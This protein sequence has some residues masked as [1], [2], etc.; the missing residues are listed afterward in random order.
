MRKSILSRKVILEWCCRC[1]VGQKSVNSTVWRNLMRQRSEPLQVTSQCCRLIGCTASVLQSG[2]LHTILN[3]CR[4]ID[5][6]IVISEVTNRE[7]AI[8]CSTGVHF[9]VSPSTGSLLNRKPVS[10]GTWEK[11][12]IVWLWNKL[13]EFKRWIKSHLLFAGIIRSSPFSPR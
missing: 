1:D 6:V 4:V 8:F 3:L 9:I 7:G 5:C 12:E 2:A 13:S 11:F 10:A